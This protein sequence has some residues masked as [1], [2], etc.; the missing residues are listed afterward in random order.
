VFKVANFIEDHHQDFLTK[1]GLVSDHDIQRASQDLGIEFDQEFKSY[2]LRFG[3]I[4]FHSME[5]CGLGVPDSSYLNIV[6]ATKKAISQVSCMPENSVVIEEIG[7]ANFVAYQM[8][9]GVVQVSAN[10]SKD[11]DLSLQDYLLMRFREEL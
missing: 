10:E 6:V 1:D 9:H 8:N 7:E 4:S 11:L 3:K 5:L 2:L